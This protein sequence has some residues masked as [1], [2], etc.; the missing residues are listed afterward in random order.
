MDRFGDLD[1]ERFGDLDRERFGESDR[2]GF[3][4]REEEPERELGDAVFWI[5]DLFGGPCGG[6]LAFFEVE[7]DSLERRRL[8]SLAARPGLCLSTSGTVRYLAVFPSLDW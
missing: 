1:R 3:R 8:S 5:G 6:D 7:E 4:P 2:P